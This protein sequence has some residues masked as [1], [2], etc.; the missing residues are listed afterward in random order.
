MVGTYPIQERLKTHTMTILSLILLLLSVVSFTVTYAISQLQQHGK[1]KWSTGS[2]R[3]DVRFGFWDNNSDERK[4][5]WVN[6]DK[7][8]PPN[9][10]Y[11][12]FNRLKYRERFP[13][14]A[15]IFVF[16]TDGY[17]LMQFISLLSISLAFGV[18]LD[19]WW[20]WALI[21]RCWISLTFFLTYNFLQR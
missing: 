2:H 10:W 11:Y 20:M 13:A 8:S 12:K 1:L 7:Q 3:S 4:Y 5:R 9:T 6:G 15:T 19:P 18:L 21:I 14:S 17:H 16:L